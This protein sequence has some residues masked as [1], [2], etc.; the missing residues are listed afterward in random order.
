MA[1]ALPDRPPVSRA[2]RCCRI[3]RRC[4][5]RRGAAGSA[6]GV[7]GGTV[8]DVLLFSFRAFLILSRF[9][10]AGGLSD[11][12]PVSRGFILFSFC[13]LLLL[14]R[15]IRRRAT[16]VQGGT[17]AAA[18]P[19]RLPV[20]RAARRVHIYRVTRDA[21]PVSRAARRLAIGQNH[22]QTRMQAPAKK[23]FTPVGGNLPA[24]KKVCEKGLTGVQTPCYSCTITTGC[25]PRNTTPQNRRS[26]P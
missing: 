18:L 7:Q 10:P 25:K 11:R 26:T 21:L 14:F 2:A 5:G 19:D 3:G 6:A 12:L 9:N 15:D 24:R 13:F 17:V 1:A 22:F 8:A 20:S 23:L 16:G 4:P